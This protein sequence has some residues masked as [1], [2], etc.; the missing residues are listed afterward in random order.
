MV[1]SRKARIPKVQKSQDD[2]DESDAKATV[3]STT[4]TSSQYFLDKVDKF[5]EDKTTRLLASG[6]QLQS[7]DAMSEDDEVMPLDIEDDDES[8]SSLSEDDLP[9]ELPGRLKK[10]LHHGKTAF[11]DNDDSEERESMASDLEEHRHDEM[12]NELAWG[13]KKKLYYDTDYVANDRKKGVNREEEEAE[14]DEEEAEAQ[15]VQKRLA[16]N[17]DEDDY[18]LDLLQAFPQKK[19][20][21]Q[22]I[23]KD[24]K[25]MS[26]K[27]K[28]KMLKK[29]S[30]ELLEL[31]EDLRGKLT[32]LREDLEPLVKMVKDGIVPPGNGSHY[33][34]TKYQLYLNY[35]TNISYYFVLKA[36]RIP[37]HGHPVIERL[38]SYRNLIND[39]GVVDQ[40]LS[41]EINFLLNKMNKKG[42]LTKSISAINHPSTEL[43]MKTSKLPKRTTYEEIAV[44]QVDDLES[45]DEAALKYYREMEKMVKN[46]RTRA[47]EVIEADQGDTED[48]G[49]DAK[50][51]ITRLIAKNRGLTPRRK[52]I[53]RN[54]RVKHREKFRRAKI[55]RKGQVREVR[56][57]ESRY[58]GELSGIRAGVKK[59][60]KLK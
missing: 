22:K 46:K 60:I 38:V 58:S 8:D 54:P 59:S 2:D 35:C 31:L 50:R 5:H 49:P 12:P 55:R 51:A 57:E 1:K 10:K 11:R 16:G 45:N 13:Q 30:P 14:A 44:E 40:R 18:G 4:D 24:L 20:A 27:E 43:K 15:R 7:D 53:D 28:L 41:T 36:K 3:P 21:G 23:E 52:K 42:V 25:K 6:I 39:L 29:E 17:L 37:V 19:S 48:V 33:I 47:P 56:K 9:I 26:E 34:Q 32:E